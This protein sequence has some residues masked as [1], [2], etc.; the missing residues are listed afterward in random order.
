MIRRW[1]EQWGRQ[2]YGLYKILSDAWT[3]TGLHPVYLTRTETWFFNHPF[4]SSSICFQSL[5]GIYIPLAPC[6]CDLQISK[7]VGKGHVKAQQ[8]FLYTGLQNNLKTEMKCTGGVNPSKMKVQWA[9]SWGIPSGCQ[10]LL[11]AQQQW[12]PATAAGPDLEDAG[13]SCLPGW[14]GGGCQELLQA[15]VPAPTASTHCRLNI[16]K[17]GCWHLLSTPAWWQQMP[18]AAPSPN[19]AAMD[20]KSCCQGAEVADVGGWA[21]C[22]SLKPCQLNSGGGGEEMGSLPMSLVPLPPVFIV[23]LTNH[24]VQ[25]NWLLSHLCSDCSIPPHVV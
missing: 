5:A 7:S 16:K 12:T 19:A 22:C 3:P 2:D 25:N 20:V 10:P 23:F 6:G 4:N 11:W 17:W 13:S 9:K 24:A 21:Q 15:L 18:A 8:I 14:H 1:V